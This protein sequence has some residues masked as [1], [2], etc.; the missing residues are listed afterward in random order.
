M[1]TVKE[2]NVEKFIECK[3]FFK[4]FLK[5][6]F[7]FFTLVSNFPQFISHYLTLKFNH[8][9]IQSVFLAALTLKMNVLSRFSTLL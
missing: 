1:A 9:L 3:T 2:N 8:F 6:S 7:N 4:I 5:Y